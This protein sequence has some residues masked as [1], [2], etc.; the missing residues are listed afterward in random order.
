MNYLMAMIDDFGFPFLHGFLWDRTR[1]VRKDLNVQ[2]IKH[3]DRHIWLVCF[4]QCARF[5]LLCLHHMAGTNDKGY[6]HEQDVEQLQATLLS[7]RQ[8]Y[9][10]NRRQGIITPNEAEFQAYRIIIGVVTH[11]HLTI[12]GEIQGLP[13]SLQRNPRIQTALQ[14][15]R[16]AK[17]VINMKEKPFKPRAAQQNWNAFWNLIKSPAVS[18]LMACAAEL[19][20][21]TIR[22]V[23]L[24]SIHRIYR[25]FMTEKGKKV[26]KQIKDW[27]VTDLVHVLG[28]DTEQEVRDFCGLY[29]FSFGITAEGE[30]FL[31]ISSAHQN[32]SQL[33]RPD[34][35]PAQTF[36]HKLVEFKRYSRALSAV[37]KGKSVVDARRDGLIVE[38]ES[39]LTELIDGETGTNI[40]AGRT[41]GVESDAEDSLFVSDTSAPI[42]S[43]MFSSGPTTS[44]FQ[45]LNPSANPFHPSDTLVRE[46]VVSSKPSFTQSNPFLQSSSTARPTANPFAPP[47]GFSP[48]SG[49]S[50]DKTP[51]QSSFGKP[52]TF[53]S[54]AS[55]KTPTAPA[56][57]LPSFATETATTQTVQPGL[58]DPLKNTVKFSSPSAF[59]SPSASTTISPK[60]SAQN[61]SPYS[62]SH[63]IPAEG[64]S[65]NSATSSVSPFQSFPAQ[66]KSSPLHFK[67]LQSQALRIW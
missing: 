52:S 43:S 29:G 60:L 20:F 56:T 66:E 14:I 7:L 59:T 61:P 5:H 32:T 28:F 16:A 65:A 15:F 4:E 50:K 2:A 67:N 39:E 55:T 34:K 30:S 11:E 9:I 42:G 21:Q 27:N 23:I 24:D 1:A 17:T 26:E 6:N 62:F 49:N 58:F 3:E 48:L 36:S 53:T 51:F 37:I 10:D 8:K 31:D 33:Q 57:T 12:E 18:H 63:T 41:I 64:K 25:Q 47:P 38:S 22:H 44:S 40:E 45:Q 13:E 46:S 35:A 19:L 54:S